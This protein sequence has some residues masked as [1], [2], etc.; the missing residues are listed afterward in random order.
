MNTSK[1]RTVLCKCMMNYAW[2]CTATSV[3][4]DRIEHISGLT[5]S[6]HPQLQAHTVAVF[7]E[8]YAARDAAGDVPQIYPGY[9]SPLNF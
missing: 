7:L 5:S 9:A 2:S 1:L 6:L 3:E 4:A 8:V